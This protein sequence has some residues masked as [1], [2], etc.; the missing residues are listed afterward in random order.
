LTESLIGRK[1]I[2]QKG[3]LTDFSAKSRLTA[4]TFDKIIQPKSYLEAFLKRGHLIEIYL[5]GSGSFYQKII[6]PTFSTE[7]FLTEKSVGA[8]SPNAV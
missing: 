8:I 1:I 5:T 2:S 3:H 6:S 7:R 4:S